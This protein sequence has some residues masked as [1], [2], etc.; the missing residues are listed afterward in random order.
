[1]YGPAFFACRPMRLYLPVNKDN[2]R[3]IRSYEKHGFVYDDDEDKKPVS[4]I[5]VNRM[6]WKTS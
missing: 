6:R 1:M 4:G 5:E 2:A 3:A